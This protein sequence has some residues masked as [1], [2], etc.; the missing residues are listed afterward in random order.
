MSYG[1][2]CSSRIGEHYDNIACVLL[3]TLEITE[4]DEDYM[5]V[6]VIWS[7]SA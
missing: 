1:R 4:E 5:K 6:N 3:G 2:Q 7:F